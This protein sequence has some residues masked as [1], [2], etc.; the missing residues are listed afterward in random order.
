MN[1]LLIIV[2]CIILSIWACAHQPKFC[3]GVGDLQICAYDT[4]FDGRI[5]TWHHWQ[6]RNGEWVPVLYPIKVKRSE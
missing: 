4:D 6:Y 3:R 2:I 5:D 1:K